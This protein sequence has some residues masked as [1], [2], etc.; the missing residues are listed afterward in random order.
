MNPL[1]NDKLEKVTKIFIEYT[2]KVKSLTVSQDIQLKLYGL[3]KQ[4]NFGDNTTPQ[5]NF[6]DLRGLAKWNAWNKYKNQSTYNSMK[7]YIKLVKSL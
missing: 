2:E 5:P 7:R 3:F 4:V 6:F 1:E